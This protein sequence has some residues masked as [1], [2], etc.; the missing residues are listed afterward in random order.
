MRPWATILDGE[1]LAIWARHM[2]D[3]EILAL[4]ASAQCLVDPPAREGER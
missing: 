2:G 1:L 4:V 3:A